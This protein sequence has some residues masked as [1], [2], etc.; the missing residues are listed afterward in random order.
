MA[1][2][3][4]IIFNL[5]MTSAEAEKSLEK[6]KKNISDTN[7]EV[8][9][10]INN[11][12]IFGVTVGDVKNKFNELKGIASKSLSI[13][14]QQGQ[15]AALG[16]RLMFG[17]KMKM[18][19][20]SLFKTIKVG[21]ASTGIG[22]LI[23]AIGS[24][25]T[26]LTQTKKGAEL[27]EVAFRTVG[28]A[29]S[30]ITDR[31][32][33]IGSAIVKVFKGDF[34]GAA[35]D[36]KKAVTGL[37]DE[38]RK[39]VKAMNELA[40][41]SIALRDSQRELNVETARRRA[42]LEALKL[43]AEDTTK[44]DKE[45]LEAARAAMELET[46]LVEKRVANAAE[47]VRILKEELGTREAT[48]DELDELA[49]LEIDLFN[50]KAEST[51]K[52][53]EL[54]NKINSIEKE[55]EA[56]RLQ[57][58]KDEEQARKEAAEARAKDFEEAEKLQ[59]ELFKAEEERVKKEKEL[60]KQAALDKIAQ[61]K[62]VADSKIAVSSAALGAVADIFGRESQA[63]KAAAVAQ[64]T[65]NTYQ[66]ANNALANTPAPPP[67]PFIAAGVALAAGFQNINKILSTPIENKFAN[68]GIVGGFGTGRSDS[69]PARLSKGESV[70]NARSTRMFRPVL[71]AIN[72][73]G[74]GRGFA[75]GGTLDEGLG[76]ITTGTVKAYVV[77]DEMTNNQERLAKI[78]RKA[79][80]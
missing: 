79:T 28:A 19:A 31:I 18:G 80:I 34:K 48:A 38:I 65:I 40:K 6:V 4:E 29:I 75:D 69:V 74:G 36:A 35:E 70:I 17:G 25:V 42:E 56:R 71:S 67:F 77:S 3:E 57:A 72:E 66:A 52:Q 45:R 33:S 68:G 12:G 49:Q 1:Q 59:E 30:V 21:I 50:I 37:G 55:A 43:I 26:Y 27:L 15:Q 62:A 58:I 7:K 46:T 44:T 16:L 61:D 20:S 76:G 60:A 9:D 22:L 78:R 47:A 51:T 10:S 53:I 11:F 39:E 54:N 8:K 23:V 73:A 64:A 32:S 63:G 5:K 24:L 13:I 14:K 41:A 2:R